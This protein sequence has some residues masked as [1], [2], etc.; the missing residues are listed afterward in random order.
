M[1]DVFVSVTTMAQQL[2]L[3]VVAEGIENDEQLALLRRFQCE[4]AQGYLFAK[5]LDVKKAAEALETGRLSWPHSADWAR[6]SIGGTRR[7]KQSLFWSLSRRWLIGPTVVLVLL[8]AGILKNSSLR[9]SSPPVSEKT[10]DIPLTSTAP[11]A[12]PERSP[13]AQETIQRGLPPTTSFHVLHQHRIGNC[14]GRLTVAST[15]IAF[16]P[17]EK[18]GSDRFSLRYRDFLYSLAES[19]LTIRSQTETYR[20]KAIVDGKKQD[21]A[22]LREVVDKISLF[23]SAGLD[24]AVTETR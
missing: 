24:P 11:I 8:T 18:T 9:H 15:G 4:A 12:A 6:S 10:G 5:P 19:R 7:R 3:Y 17:D 1:A 23:S 22:A 21:E 13:A 14:R 16:V 20:F 2:G